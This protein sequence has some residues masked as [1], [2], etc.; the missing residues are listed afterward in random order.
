M[1][2]VGKS[3]RA[4]IDE[5]QRG[6]NE[7]AM[8]HACNAIDGTAGKALPGIG[9]NV[10][11]TTLLRRGYPILGP[12][13]LPG[14]DLEQTRWP[15]KVNRPKAEGGLPDIADVIYGIHRCAHGHGDE[16]P[17]GFEL[18]PDAAESKA[19]TRIGVSSGKVQLSDRVIFGMLSIAVF[20][21]VNL[22][23]TVP[24][25]Y[26]LSFAGLNMPINQWW[27]R[28]AD[29][30]LLAATQIMPSVILNLGDWQ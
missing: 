27:G 11:F 2:S 18:W 5:W 28:E 4:A 26:F 8:L 1:A 29:F 30:L 10:R 14:I 16:L 3:V 15:V 19:T 13:G 6:D 12:V 20:S 21:P 9:N 17:D 23:Q 24:D 25:G 7:L 22:G